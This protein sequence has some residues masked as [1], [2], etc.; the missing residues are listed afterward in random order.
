MKVDNNALAKFNDT[1]I[2]C[3]AK[4]ILNLQTNRPIKRLNDY[5][6]TE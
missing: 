6:K 4:I 5:D 3:K 1:R 2:V